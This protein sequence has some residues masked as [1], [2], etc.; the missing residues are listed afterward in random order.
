MYNESKLLELAMI[1]GEVEERGKDITF[2][3]Y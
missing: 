3:S 1:D 2:R